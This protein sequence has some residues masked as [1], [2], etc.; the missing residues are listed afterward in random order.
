MFIF[1]KNDAFCI[2]FVESDRLTSFSAETKMSSD[3][4]KYDA[5]LLSLATQMSG[6]VPQLLDVL[7]N[8]LSR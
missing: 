3:Y 8:F 2:D 6:G 7:F 4:E 1:P 5:V